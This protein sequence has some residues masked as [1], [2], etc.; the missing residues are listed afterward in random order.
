MLTSQPI[1]PIITID[2]PTSSGK[3]TVSRI[4]SMRL[5]WH[6]LDSGAIYRAF[7]LASLEEQ[8]PPEDVAR[9]VALASDLHID[10]IL[11]EQKHDRILLSGVDVTEAIRQEVVSRQASRVSQYAN[12][13]KAL[14]DCQRGFLRFPGLVADGRDMGTVVFPEAKLK[15]FLSAAPEERAR[16][17]YQQLIDKGIEANLND[18]LHDLTERDHRD[19]SRDAA[20]LKPAK[21]SELIDS[22]HLSVEQVVQH[23]IDL[24]KQ[25]FSL[26]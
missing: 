22:T 5:G 23:I 6:F 17:R 14:L 1:I 18:I 26:C 21:D 13:R 10:F 25:R 11:D 15:I 4:V 8:V 20:P 7:A 3:G 24:A 12:V 9:L 19:Q 2:G 16:R